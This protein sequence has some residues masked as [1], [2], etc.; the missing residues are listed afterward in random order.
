MLKIV[1]FQIMNVIFYFTFHVKIEQINYK[2]LYS[3]C[4]GFCDVSV[5]V[6]VVLGVVVS[7]SCARSF[8]R[9]F[10]ILCDCAKL[11]EAA[12]EATR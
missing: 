8:A 4:D 10:V 9:L 6:G 11:C 2:K 3:L 5:V 7:Q 12:R 1:Y